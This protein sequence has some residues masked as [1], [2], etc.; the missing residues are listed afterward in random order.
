MKALS[1][2]MKSVFI[3]ECDRNLPE[4][5]QTKW[6]FK[7]CTLADESA[8]EDAL[9][10]KSVVGTGENEKT[11]FTP[12][13]NQQRR[14]ALSALLESVDNFTDAEG[15]RVEMEREATPDEFG[16]NRLSE[17]FLMRIPYD[18]RRELAA[19]AMGLIKPSKADVKN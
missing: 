15:N 7:A 12:N 14:V 1:P 17:S 19:H 11:I 13:L 18:I 5:E 9:F 2:R 16:I 4:N 6:S 10:T 8:I 3:A